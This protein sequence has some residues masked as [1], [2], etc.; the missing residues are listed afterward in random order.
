MLYLICMQSNNKELL[1]SGS[2]D[3]TLF[4]WEPTDNKKSLA[5]MTGALILHTLFPLNLVLLW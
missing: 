4:L 3:F 5:R 1:V 2:D